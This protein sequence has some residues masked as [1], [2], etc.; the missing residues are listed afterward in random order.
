MAF[1]FVQNGEANNLTRPYLLSRCLRQL[2]AA[3]V[4]LTSYQAID[5]RGRSTAATLCCQLTATTPLTLH[6]V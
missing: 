3:G 2:G 4:K 6:T 5:G 1:F